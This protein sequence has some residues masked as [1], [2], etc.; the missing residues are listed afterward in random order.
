[1]S[2]KIKYGNQYY[3][4]SLTDNSVLISKEGVSLE[5]VPDQASG[6]FVVVDP[7][8][9]KR[10]SVKEVYEDAVKYACCTIN[11]RLI[12]ESGFKAN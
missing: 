9:K 10:L 8:D 11:S 4:V 6:Y 1:M 7:V 3:E 5:I 12:D 2:E